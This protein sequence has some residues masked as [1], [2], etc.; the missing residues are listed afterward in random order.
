MPSPFFYFRVT[1]S[2]SSTASARCQTQRCQCSTRSPR[3]C[4]PLPTFAMADSP[5]PSHRAGRT[6]SRSYSPASPPPPPRRRTSRPESSPPPSSIFGIPSSPVEIERPYRLPQ[7]PT[8][9]VVRAQ[10]IIA[11]PYRA[12]NPYR[13]RRRRWITV[14]HSARRRG[15]HVSIDLGPE[16]A[17]EPVAEFPIEAEPPPIP[18]GEQ[19]HNASSPVRSPSPSEDGSISGGA[20]GGTQPPNVLIG[21]PAGD[22]EAEGSSIRRSSSGARSSISRPSL[23]FNR[24]PA[25]VLEAPPPLI[26]IG[27]PMSPPLPHV[28]LPSASTL[29]STES[30]RPRPVRPRPP[31]PSPPRHY[32]SRTRVYHPGAEFITT[33][34]EVIDE[35]Q[36]LWKTIPLQIY[37]HVLLRLPDLYWSRLDRVFRDAHKAATQTPNAQFLRDF[38]HAEG[39]P[40]VWNGFVEGVVKEWETQNIVSALLLSAIFS[41]FGFD[42]DPFTRTFAMLSFVCALMS[43]L[44]GCTYIIRFGSVKRIVEARIWIKAIQANDDRIWRYLWNEWTLLAMPAVWLAWS[45]IFFIVTLFF[46]IWRPKSS[47]SDSGDDVLNFDLGSRISATVLLGFGILYYCFVLETF[48][49]GWGEEDEYDFYDTD[50]EGGESVVRLTREEREEKEAG[51][52]PRRERLQHRTRF[53]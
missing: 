39:F 32:S 4:V 19:E 35:V 11:N 5:P 44:Y 33:R 16:P 37:L 34:T 27:P 10:P 8:I 17:A 26:V 23:E 28:I 41:I 13:S 25:P 36:P 30:F 24:P 9:P 29:S 3:T 46:F 14:D 45:I 49:I 20:P 40:E 43:L 31:V 53:D 18:V 6:R 50:T 48:R 22:A 38:T 1:G 51:K 21:A 7:R 47:S 15:R 12:S 2:S 52:P 42:S